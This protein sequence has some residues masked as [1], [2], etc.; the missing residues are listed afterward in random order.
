MPPESMTTS[1]IFTTTIRT[2]T[3]C[4]S[5]NK[6]C[7]SGKGGSTV[8]VTETIPISTTVCPISDL[9]V[10]PTASASATATGVPSSAMTPSSSVMTPSASSSSIVREP[11]VSSTAST[12][13]TKTASSPFE[14]ATG[15]DI[16][17]PEIR[18]CEKGDRLDLPGMPWAVT[19]DVSADD[20]KM[21]KQCTNFNRV[22]VSNGTYLV[23]W[24]SITNVKRTNETADVVKGYSNIEAKLN[25]THHLADIKSIPTFFRWNRTI[26]TG[27]KG[28]S[29]LCH[30]FSISLLLKL[31]LPFC[32]F[33]S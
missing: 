10:T 24:T 20:E 15:I 11:S 22:V 26:G 6:G 9:P 5:G 29:S 1:T 17:I 19:N 25:G 30:L 16:V 2:V 27:F 31:L 3:D 18:Q 28:R 13:A 33:S 21:G 4:G 7:T 12:P 32:M 8:F 23:N 14:G